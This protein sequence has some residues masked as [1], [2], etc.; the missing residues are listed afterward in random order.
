MKFKYVFLCCLSLGYTP[1]FAA[2]DQEQEILNTCKQINHFAQQGNNAYQKNQ[3]AKAL[4]A[5]KQQAS[6][7]SFCSLHE[8]LT[9]KVISDNQLA[10]A[11]NNVGLTYAKLNQPRWARA[12]YSIM[13]KEGKS[14]FNLNALGLMKSTSQKA[15]Q[16]VKYIGQGQWDTIEVKP[17]GQN[18]AIHYYGLRMGLNGLIYGPNMGEFSTVIS[19]NA[20]TARY[21]DNDYGCTIDLQFNKGDSVRVKQSQS[22]CGFGMGVYAEGYYLKVEPTPN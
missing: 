18:Y 16:Y 14:Q 13:P 4:E 5:F 3:Y 8:E 17:H 15:G 21:H 7:L 6:L 11:Y 20:Q 12:W 10:T 19:K 2:S 9:G 22:D 1:T